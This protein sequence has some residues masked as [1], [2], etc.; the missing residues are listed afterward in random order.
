MGPHRWEERQEHLARLFADDS[1]ISF[2]EGASSVEQKE[3]DLGHARRF[4]HRVYHLTCCP[5][6]IV[7]QFANSI[8]VPVE[9]KFEQMVVK[10]EPSLFVIIDNRKGL[11][12][13]AIQN[14][15]RAFS[16][17]RRMAQIMGRE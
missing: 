16:A 15:R 7:M 9:S 10:D 3:K 17:P 11:R 4:N 13:I 12:T 8:D 14:R 1:C 2:G 6:V 5:Q